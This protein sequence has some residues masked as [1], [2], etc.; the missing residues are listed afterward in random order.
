MYGWTI[1]FFSK[2]ICF[3]LKIQDNEKS[4][5]NLPLYNIPFSVWEQNNVFQSVIRVGTLVVIFVNFLWT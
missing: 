3:G 2:R 5:A 4:F 1:R